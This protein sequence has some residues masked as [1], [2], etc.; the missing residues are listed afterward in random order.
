[1]LVE[2]TSQSPDDHAG[3]A[4]IP[5]FPR[6]SLQ[7]LEDTSLVA[8]NQPENLTAT[9]LGHAKARMSTHATSSSMVQ[10]FIFH[11]KN[12]EESE[13]NEER[14]IES[15]SIQSFSEV[16]N[17]ENARQ[18]SNYYSSRESS[19]PAP[20]NFNAGRVRVDSLGAD[21]D[22]N[23][24][25]HT[26]KLDRSGSQEHFVVGGS[27]VIDEQNGK[28][29]AKRQSYENIQQK[30][31]YEEILQ[32]SDESDSE[33][34]KSQHGLDRSRKRTLSQ[35]QLQPGQTRSSSRVPSKPS[36]FGN[37]ESDHNFRRSFKRKRDKLRVSD[38]LMEVATRN[39]SSREN[40]KSSRRGSSLHITPNGSRHNSLPIL[41][42]V[43]FE[44]RS[45]SEAS[46]RRKEDHNGNSI[47]G[48]TSLASKSRDVNKR[49]RKSSRNRKIPTFYFE[50]SLMMPSSRPSKYFKRVVEG[51]AFKWD[52]MQQKVKVCI[53][54]VP[55][56]HKRNFKRS[57]KINKNVK[58]EEN[59]IP[60]TLLS[61]GTDFMVLADMR[62][63]RNK[64]TR[65]RK[66]FGKSKKSLDGFD[67][68]FVGASLDTSEPCSSV[69]TQ[70]DFLFKSNPQVKS[71]GFT[72]SAEKGEQ[73]IM[74]DNASDISVTQRY[75]NLTEFS[76]MQERHNQNQRPSFTVGALAPVERHRLPSFLSDEPLNLAYDISSRY[77]VRSTSVFFRNR[78]GRVIVK[79][80]KSKPERD[81]ITENYMSEVSN[82]FIQ[83][84]GFDRTGNDAVCNQEQ[85][86]SC[87]VRA[88]S[89]DESHNDLQIVLPYAVS[90]QY[91]VESKSFF[92]RKRVGHVIVNQGTRGETRAAIGENSVGE[93]SDAFI[94]NPVCGGLRK[95][96]DGKARVRVACVPLQ[97][98]TEDSEK[99]ATSEMKSAPVCQNPFDRTQ[100][101]LSR[102]ESGEARSQPVEHCD[103]TRT[104]KNR[105]CVE[106][107]GV[108]G[109]T[110]TQHTT[111]I[112]LD[113]FSS[114]TNGDCKSEAEIEQSYSECRGKLSEFSVTQEQ[115]D[116]KQHHPVTAETLSPIERQDVRSLVSDEPFVLL[117][118]ISNQDPAESMFKIEQNTSHP[119]GY[120]IGENSWSEV[121]HALIQKSDCDGVGD[122]SELHDRLHS[123]DISLQQKTVDLEAD[124][125]SKMMSTHGCQTSFD[126][127]HSV[128]NQQES[129]DARSQSVEHCNTT[130]TPKK[131]DEAL[132]LSEMSGVEGT[133]SP[134]HLSLNGMYNL[135]SISNAE[136]KSTEARA[137]H[138]DCRGNLSD[139]SSSQE[140]CDH[141]Q[142]HSFNKD[143]LS[144]IERHHIPPLV[145]DE[146][147]ILPYDISSQYPMK[148]APFFFENRTGH[149][150]INLDTNEPQ[151]DEM[152]LNTRIQNSSCDGA[153][154]GSDGQV[155]LPVI[156][157]YLQQAKVNATAEMKPTTFYQ[158]SWDPSL[159]IINQQE[160]QEP[161]IHN[162]EDPKKKKSSTNQEEISYISEAP[163]V[164]ATS[165]STK[166]VICI[167]NLPS[168]QKENF[169]SNESIVADSS[170]CHGNRSEFFTTQVQYNQE[171]GPS[172]TI[173]TLSPKENYRSLFPASDEPLV[174]PYV[175][176][177]QSCLESKSLFYKKCA[178]FVIIKWDRSEVGSCTVA[179]TRINTRSNSSK[180]FC[181]SMDKT[182]QRE[183]DCLTKERNIA[184][185]NAVSAFPK[186]IKSGSI[187]ES[188]Q[189]SERSVASLEMSHQSKT[190]DTDLLDRPHRKRGRP[191]LSSQHRAD[192]RMKKELQS[193]SVSHG[194]KMVKPKKGSVF[195]NDWRVVGDPF[196]TKPSNNGGYLV[197]FSVLLDRYDLDAT[198]GVVER[199][200]FG[201]T[202]DT[203]KL[204]IDEKIAEL[205]SRGVEI[206]N[207]ESETMEEINHQRRTL[208]LLT[209]YEQQER[210]A[211]AHE[212]QEDSMAV[213]VHEYTRRRSK[214]SKH[215]VDA[216]NLSKSPIIFQAYA[217]CHITTSSC[218]PDCPLCSDKEHKTAIQ[219]N[220][221]ISFM[222]LYRRFNIDDL[223]ENDED[224]GDSQNGVSRVRSKR[225]A[226]VSKKG[227]QSVMKLIELKRTLEFVEQYYIDNKNIW[228]I[229]VT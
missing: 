188:I 168:V 123:A 203:A 194:D 51:S 14:S 35:S 150:S 38:S 66:S 219:A 19:L 105:D 101:L 153:G 170:E 93:V 50:E 138:S 160:Y 217:D 77:P 43:A 90:N 186:A 193:S 214:K 152:A 99:D 84:S 109:T 53:T 132:C 89:A 92:Y 70:S 80:D 143:V 56:P 139:I 64:R 68:S 200:E 224:C 34:E 45:D 175:I 221:N 30:V 190:C 179:P 201:S 195:K 129:G 125:T 76:S 85:R 197:S 167:D 119:Q 157:N 122:G 5:S 113:N 114:I 137:K 75:S 49:E 33:R 52:Q 187:R 20:E 69:S 133:I 211:R 229:T 26:K 55:A 177:N 196:P 180:V 174:L 98:T 39:V 78:V 31:T 12:G 183:D 158:N 156:D 144:P 207:D 48:D 228:G 94:E 226:F 111:L 162:A 147:F 79:W 91:P 25:V 115:C 172:C 61:D 171:K 110:T 73:S 210:L 40:R 83:N 206:S 108:E 191:S 86:Y 155:L 42:S 17:H 87:T 103:T 220:P 169:K 2:R 141:E 213:R 6:C 192:D 46:F 173:Q 189:A 134:Q 81:T 124:P 28:P 95:G 204:A 148:S 184:V 185:D 88:L 130:M 118:D 164:E 117:Y 58:H 59:S 140:P 29:K 212:K 47:S 205:R 15:V 135:P 131:H 13:T 121:S 208:K 21:S 16:D 3:A 178:G 36:Y 23:L 41:G 223:D 146:T 1:M 102:Q 9:P 104:T 181:D 11:R 151:Q 37:I 72:P 149:I 209:S 27:R 145:P 225:A 22:K 142:H 159:S 107:S 63:H 96:S 82:V 126:L 112:D 154:L 18:K 54:D 127:T 120:A 57:E 60:R 74:S 71:C 65:N 44:E 32:K 182:L 10:S 202:I 128:L 67:E 100:S 8:D 4:N 116:R 136:L 227:Q 176:S 161:S 165:S 62:S 216:Q 106:M 198:R 215:E 222:P 97:Q 166:N 218:S 163:G 24:T 7:T 199:V